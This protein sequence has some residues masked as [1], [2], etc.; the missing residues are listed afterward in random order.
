MIRTS[1]RLS[2]LI[3][4]AW[5]AGSCN[6]TDKEEPGTAG[7][8]GNAIIKVS[9]KHHSDEIDSCRVYIRYNSLDAAATYDDSTWVVQE[10]G[11]PVATFSGL[12]KGKYYLFGNGWDPGVMQPVRGGLPVTIVEDKVYNLVLPVTEVH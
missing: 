5:S 6:R 10:N 11:S 3:L 8:G 12:K 7:K 2:L 9:P 4:F 1:I